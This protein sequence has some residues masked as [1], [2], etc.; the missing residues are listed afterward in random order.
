MGAA[1]EIALFFSVFKP[2]HKLLGPLRSTG[3]NGLLQIY[4]NVFSAFQCLMK[5]ESNPCVSSKQ[6]TNYIWVKEMMIAVLLIL[7]SGGN[8]LLH[9]KR[10][11]KTK[12]QSFIIRLLKQK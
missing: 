3:L 2:T 6:T 12:L 10:S 11:E 5:R 9:F 8:H 7:Q 4:F 1:F